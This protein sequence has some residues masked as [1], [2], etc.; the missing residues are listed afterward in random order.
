MLSGVF[1]TLYNATCASIGASVGN[2]RHGI[3]PK[4]PM[5]FGFGTEVM[6]YTL[7]SKFQSHVISMAGNFN[8]AAPRKRAVLAEQELGA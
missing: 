1:A 4:A 7:S 8:K 3:A 2:M 6:L 5:F